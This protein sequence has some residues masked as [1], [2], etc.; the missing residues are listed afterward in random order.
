MIQ[1][2]QVQV[3]NPILII[4]LLP[5]MEGI[6]YPCLTKIGLPHRYMFTRNLRFATVVSLICSLMWQYGYVKKLSFDRPLQ[7]LGAGMFLTATAFL[8]AAGMQVVINVCNLTYSLEYWFQIEYFVFTSICS[9]M[10]PCHLFA[11]RITSCYSYRHGS[12][13]SDEHS[14]LC[15]HNPKRRAQQWSISA[16]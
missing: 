12:I 8:M 1:P 16:G 5:L 3:F 6:F 10:H 14:S 11:G 2:D 7:R 4:I 15:N 9:I 13:Q